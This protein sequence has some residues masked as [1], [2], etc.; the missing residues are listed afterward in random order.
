MLFGVLGLASSLLGLGM[1]LLTAPHLWWI[2]VIP[3]AIGTTTVPAWYHHTGPATARRLRFDLRGL[4][5]LI[6]LTSLILGGITSQYRQM[7]IEEQ[8]ATTL[9]AL[10]ESSSNQIRWS[11]GRVTE[12]IFINSRSS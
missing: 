12:V 2:A 10:P 5:A 11:L 3:I 8:A 1:L 4:F 7:R 6:L 9:E